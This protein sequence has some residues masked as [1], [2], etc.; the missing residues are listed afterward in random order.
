MST[1]WAD[2]ME[3][4]NTLV[5]RGGAKAAPHRAT[6]A[7]ASQ[8]APWY[9]GLLAG[10]AWLA[11]A[12]VTGVWEDINEWTYTA[13]LAAIEAAIGGVLLAIGLAGSL[14]GPVLARLERSGPWL[15]ALGLSAAA[16]EAVT[17]KLLLLP[18]PFFV[19]P[20]G[21][22]EAYLDDWPRL[23]ECAYHSIALLGVGFGVGRQPALSPGSRSAGRKPPPIG[24]IRSC[25]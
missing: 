10:L 8:Y 20:Q 4:A 1:C 16:W 9:G 25:A 14:S 7:S 12:L 6:P 22:L 5:L 19:P 3:T 13:Q 21:L 11:A 17:A 2:P 15:V 18:P 23:F 24:A